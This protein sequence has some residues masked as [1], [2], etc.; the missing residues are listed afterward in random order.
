MQDRLR[1]LLPLSAAIN[2]HYGAVKGDFLGTP[3]DAEHPPEWMPCKE[4]ACSEMLLNMYADAEL[5]PVFGDDHSFHHHCSELT[6]AVRP[7]LLRLL[8]EE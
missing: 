2:L 4:E 8:A 7:F 3:F 5:V 6:A 1:A